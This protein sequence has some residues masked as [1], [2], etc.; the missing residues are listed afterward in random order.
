[1]I[2]WR[3]SGTARRMYERAQNSDARLRRCIPKQ[4]FDSL[5]A[6]Q[7]AEQFVEM[8]KQIVVDRQGVAQ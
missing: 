1:L 8:V 2:L 7:D 3:L 5:A 4:Y 6:C